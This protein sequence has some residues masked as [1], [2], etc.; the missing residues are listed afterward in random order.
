MQNKPVQMSLE[1][2]T[3]GITI[4][5]VDFG[6]GIDKKKLESIFEPFYRVETARSRDLG[7]YGIGL[8]LCK[9]IIDAHQ[10]TISV[11]SEPG[12]GTTMEVTLPASR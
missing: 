1:E 2:T 8:F 3:T 4:K 7:G 11:T 6:I 10:G 9:R 5:I 12:I